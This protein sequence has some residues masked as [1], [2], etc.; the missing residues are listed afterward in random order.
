MSYLSYMLSIVFVGVGPRIRFVFH[1]KCFL[2]H[3]GC[4]CSVGGYTA[5]NVLKCMVAFQWF[6]LLFTG[7]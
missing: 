5:A 6:W 4:I 2:D 3:V 7:C 1:L